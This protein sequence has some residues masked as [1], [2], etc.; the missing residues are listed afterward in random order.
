MLHHV[1]FVWNG[2]DVKDKE[3]LKKA[4]YIIHKKLGLSGSVYD[5]EFC[6]IYEFEGYDKV[7]ELSKGSSYI[8]MPLVR[9]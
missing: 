7:R 6:S 1:Q 9:P 8:A 3:Q 2:S 5:W 4:F